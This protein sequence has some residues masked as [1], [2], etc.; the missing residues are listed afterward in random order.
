MALY[1]P[2]LYVQWEKDW[3]KKMVQQLELY[4]TTQDFT[5]PELFAILKDLYVPPQIVISLLRLSQRLEIE[6]LHPRFYSAVNRKITQIIKPLLI[7]YNAGF[8]READVIMA[9]KER[10]K[11]TKVIKRDSSGKSIKD[12][13]KEMVGRAS[14]E[15]RI[16]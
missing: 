8:A 15:E 11:R 7:M 13:L 5:H 3:R 2:A 16:V 6:G 9:G 12:K 14:P 4:V 10:D 1:D